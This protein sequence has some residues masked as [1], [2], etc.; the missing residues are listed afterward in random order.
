MQDGLKPRYVRARH[1]KHDTQTHDYYRVHGN[2]G[3]APH[4]RFTPSEINFVVRFLINYAEQNAIL[5]P[6]RIPGYKSANISLLP[7]STSKR[8]L[9]L[10]YQQAA[11]QQGIRAAHRSYF[12]KLWKQLLPHIVVCKPRSDLCWTCQKN[13][14]AIMRTA[15]TALE[16]KSQ[17][18]LHGNKI[19]VTLTYR[20]L[21][22]QCNT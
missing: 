1:N 9:W 12:D 6:G 3:K 7:S 19:I 8:R 10:I 18:I 14:V 13:S 5:L 2:T 22:M 17:V 15:N 16:Q 11:Q 20:Q 4:N 21:T